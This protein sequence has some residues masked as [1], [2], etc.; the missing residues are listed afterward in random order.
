[1]ESGIPC[2]VVILTLLTF[3]LFIAWGNARGELDSIKKDQQR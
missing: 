3:I 2:G 1:M